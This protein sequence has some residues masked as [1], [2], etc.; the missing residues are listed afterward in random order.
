[1]EDLMKFSADIKM[2]AN[3]ALFGF[4]YITICGHCKKA[5]EKVVE[6]VD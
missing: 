4:S 1:M 2:F 5:Y 3:K 6:E